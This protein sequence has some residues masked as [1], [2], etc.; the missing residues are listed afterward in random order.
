MNVEDFF[1]EGT[2]PA[3]LPNAGTHFYCLW[4]KADLVR[5]GQLLR[6]KYPN[7]L[8]YD[9]LSLLDEER[10]DFKIRIVESWSRAS[11]ERTKR[12]RSAA[13]L[14]STLPGSSQPMTTR[15]R[16]R[17]GLP[18]GVGPGRQPC[19][20]PG[21]GEGQESGQAQNVGVTRPVPAI[22]WCPPAYR[23]R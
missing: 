15:S 1:L 22:F 20:S 12:T 17:T 2:R 13:H 11:R 9:S 16:E 21:H 4:S 5:F 19:P 23:S 10:E 18:S 6:K 7:V 14:P 8:F 3:I